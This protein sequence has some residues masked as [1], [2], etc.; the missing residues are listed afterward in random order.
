MDS[1]V[2]PWILRGILSLPAHLFLSPLC[3][4]DRVFSQQGAIV[5]TGEQAPDLESLLHPTLQK[6]KTKQNKTLRQR[7]TKV[8]CMKS[9]INNQ[10]APSKT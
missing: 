3:L 4:W 9:K 8:T 6:N 10:T 5:E 2:S 1:Q 7:M